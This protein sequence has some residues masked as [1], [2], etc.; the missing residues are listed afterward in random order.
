M[1]T[2]QIVVADIHGGFCRCKSHV[3]HRSTA[4][5]LWLWLTYTQAPPTLPYLAICSKLGQPQPG[6]LTKVRG[7]LN[8]D[9]QNLFKYVNHNQSVV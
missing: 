5:W 2:S 6:F 3:L 8:D 9:R 1:Y 7:Q 4:L